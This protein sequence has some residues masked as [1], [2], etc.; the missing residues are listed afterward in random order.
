MKTSRPGV[1]VCVCL[2]GTDQVQVCGLSQQL[3]VGPA[4]VDPRL[5]VHLVP[6]Q[7]ERGTSEGPEG[8]E[9][10]WVEGGRRRSYWTMSGLVLKVN[11]R[12]SCAEMA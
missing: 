7:K 11:G 9:V 3:H 8:G 5:E 2:C 4:A 1:C 10:R 12:S 6:A